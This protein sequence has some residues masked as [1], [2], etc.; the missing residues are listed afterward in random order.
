MA[1]WFTR[2][3]AGAETKS[4][5]Q[6]HG[7]VDAAIGAVRRAPNRGTEEILKAYSDSPWVYAA[8]KKVAEHVA[9]V[10]TLLYAA[11]PKGRK[12]LKMPAL[13][14]A[15]DAYRKRMMA[16]RKQ[17]GELREILEHPMLSLLYRPNDSMVGPQLLKVLTE[18]LILTGNALAMVILDQQMRPM[19]LYPIPLHWVQQVPSESDPVFVVTIGGRRVSVPQELMLWYRY[20]DPADPYGFGVG[21][22]T[23]LADEIDVDLYASKMLKSG[24]YNDGVMGKIVGVSGVESQEQMDA[25]KA[26][27]AEQH[28]GPYRARLPMFHTGDIDV[29]DLGDG[30]KDMQVAELRTWERDAIQSI[31]GVPPEVLGH[32]VAGTRATSYQAQ[33]IMNEGVVKP[34]LELF[35]EVHQSFLAPFWDDRLI[36]DYLPPHVDDRELQLEAAKA[37]PEAL[38]RADWRE[39]AGFESRGDV[40]DVHIV[41]GVVQYLRPEDMPAVIEPAGAPTEKSH[42]RNPYALGVDWSDDKE[43]D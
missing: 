15:Q 22:G 24:F 11:G 35:R 13:Q 36:V 40:D 2:L 28:R 17:A 41:K 1:N 9:A 30:F 37:L 6:S 43:G 33:R 20:L 26:K 21:A 19:E 27:F 5:G 18:Q 7:S 14:H 12:A 16:Q 31:F 3:F 8:V 29:K 34:I 39:L 10:P 32:T 25:L 4:P 23:A 42:R 38:T